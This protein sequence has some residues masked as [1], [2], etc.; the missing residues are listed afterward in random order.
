MGVPLTKGGNM[1]LNRQAPGLTAVTAGL[2]WQ[3]GSPSGG[4]CDLDAGAP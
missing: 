1:S 4:D 2:G 3:A